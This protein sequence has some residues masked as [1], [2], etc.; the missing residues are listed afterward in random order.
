MVDGFLEIRKRTDL[1][2]FLRLVGDIA[3]LRLW[4]LVGDLCNSSLQSLQSTAP[5]QVHED[6]A[7]VL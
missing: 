5:L 2:T 7:E 1:V 4:K 3:A 6:G